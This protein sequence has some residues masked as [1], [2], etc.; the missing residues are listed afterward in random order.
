MGN[1]S[2]NVYVACGIVKSEPPQE[3][4]RRRDWKEEV[5]YTHRSQSVATGYHAGPQGRK[6]QEADINS[7]RK[8]CA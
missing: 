5:Y 3:E 2:K 8:A 1:C 4:M 6:S 7:K